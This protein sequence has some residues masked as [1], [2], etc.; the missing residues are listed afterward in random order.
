MKLIMQKNGFCQGVELKRKPTKEE[1]IYCLTEILSFN[2]DDAF[3]D[4]DDWDEEMEEIYKVFIDFIKGECDWHYLCDAVYCYDYDDVTI[5]IFAHLLQYL[6][7]H[8][9]I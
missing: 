6:E 2:L 5:G 8:G 7:E 3:E 4:I 1:A 9:V